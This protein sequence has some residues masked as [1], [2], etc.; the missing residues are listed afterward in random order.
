M[1]GRRI[2]GK[3]TGKELNQALLE[4]AK[5]LD[6]VL[7]KKEAQLLRSHATALDEL[8]RAQD[9]F[10]A[11][12]PIG[13]KST[14][15]RACDEESKPKK[16]LERPPPACWR[17]GDTGHRLK[18]CTAMVLASIGTPPNGQGDDPKLTSWEDIVAHAEE[19]ADAK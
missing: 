12:V 4:G 3:R 17:C 9:A 14:K 15:S 16:K 11:S 7:R 18:D 1:T 13:V 19:K 5:A 2:P 10:W 8:Q 6:L